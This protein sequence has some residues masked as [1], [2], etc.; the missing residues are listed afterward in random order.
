MAG[1]RASA[2]RPFF[3]R[4]HRANRGASR[5][6]EFAVRAAGLAGRNGSPRDRDVV[7]FTK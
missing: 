2:A 3:V 4:E 5:A 6:V 7:Q 1:R